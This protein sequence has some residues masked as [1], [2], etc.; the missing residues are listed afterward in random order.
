MI[1]RRSEFRERSLK[2]FLGGAPE[3]NAEIVVDLLKGGKGPKRD[4]IVL[5]AGAAITASGKVDSLEAGI[6][7]AAESIDSGAALAKLEGLKAR[8]K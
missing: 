1:R 8:F 3:E 5:N 4:I 6:E 2:H 7:R